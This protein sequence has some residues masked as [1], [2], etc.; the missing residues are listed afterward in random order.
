MPPTKR[1]RRRKAPAKKKTAG[2]RRKAPAKKKTAGSRRKAPAKKKTAG[3]RSKAPAKKSPTAPRQSTMVARR[4]RAFLVFTFE[5]LA[6]LFGS[7]AF[8]LVNDG[9][10]TP[11]EAG[12]LFGSGFLVAI[13]VLGALLGQVQVLEARVEVAGETKEY[14]Q[15]L[16]ETAKDIEESSPPGDLTRTAA[17]A[18]D[19]FLETTA[20]KG[21]S[22]L[23]KDYDVLKK[24][25]RRTM[26]VLQLLG[27]IALVVAFV[28]VFLLLQDLPKADT[29][30]VLEKLT[31]SIPGAV[32][33]TYF[34]AEAS[35]YRRLAISSSL[36]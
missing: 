2:S 36:W 26:L 10:L 20:A 8:L 22:Q 27:L 28:A 12:S 1:V 35:V 17:E 31:I 15:D 19:A 16:K 4:Q 11:V 30:A 24:S 7:M 21:E 33:F 9:T 14:R 23:S 29:G 32:I 25:A 5:A 13:G 18:V 34:S 3:S 6:L